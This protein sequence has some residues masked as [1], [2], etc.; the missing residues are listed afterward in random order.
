MNFTKKG[1]Q[2]YRT[3]TDKCFGQEKANNSSGKKE[4]LSL[5]KQATKSKTKLDQYE[6]M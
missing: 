4:A 5:I 3:I 2:K 1:G 6:M